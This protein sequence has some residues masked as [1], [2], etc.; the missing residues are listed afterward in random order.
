MSAS[1]RNQT[2]V[3]GKYASYRISGGEKLKKPDLGQTLGILANV[4]VLLGILLLVY[5]LAQNRQMMRAQTR[6]QIATEIVG[7]LG[8]INPQFA[9]VF[10]RGISGEELTPDEEIQFRYRQLTVFRYFE[11]VHYQYR[12]GLYDE[13]EFSAQ[14]E[15]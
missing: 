9:S 12:Q 1:G 10:R 4:G 8:D 3:K 6:T 13:V 2:L 7:L 5:E 11:N 14:K 15:A